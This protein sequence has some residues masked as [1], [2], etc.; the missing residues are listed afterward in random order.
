MASMEWIPALIRDVSAARRAGVAAMICPGVCYS[1]AHV[2]SDHNNESNGVIQG[3]AIE[4]SGGRRITATHISPG[5]SDRC[6]TTFLNTMIE[7]G[8]NAT[9]IVGDFNARARELDTTKNERR[10]AIKRGIRRTNYKVATPGCPTFHSRGGQ[11]SS[12][13]DLLISNVGGGSVTA[14]TGGLWEGASDHTPALYEKNMWETERD[15]ARRRGTAKKITVCSC[16]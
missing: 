2:Y 6:V 1:I 8:G 15:R 14:L 12:C 5:S 16:D 4:L 7:E 13:P 3:L 10:K 9:W 11:G